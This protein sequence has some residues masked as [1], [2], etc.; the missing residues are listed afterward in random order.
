MY[1]INGNGIFSRKLDYTNKIKNILKENGNQ[2]ITTLRVGRRILAKKIEKAFNVI[3]AGKWERLKKDYYRDN[4]F[5]I[6]IVITLENGITY[7]LEKNSVI[8]INEDLSCSESNIECRDVSKYTENS[9]TLEDFIKEPVESIGKKEYFEYDPFKQNCGHFIMGILR[10][11]NLLDNTI[12]NFIEQDVSE[13]VKRLPFYVKWSAKA[14][15]D[16]IAFKSKIKGDGVNY[17]HKMHDGTI[18]KGKTHGGN[19]DLEEIS[20]FVLEMFED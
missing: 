13:I 2:K 1:R 16:A 10:H 12:K 19:N 8:N 7:L 6:F 11:F 9:I 18:M 17:T 3:S 15:T 4:L 5:H 20:K 14:T